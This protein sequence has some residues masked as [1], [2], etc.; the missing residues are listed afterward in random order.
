[1]G[2]GGAAKRQ[3]S[4]AGAHTGQHAPSLPDEIHGL[5]GLQTCLH[6]RDGDEQGG[7][8]QARHTVHG[9]GGFCRR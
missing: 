4:K 8:A 3:L 5:H 2:D 9:D 7:A 6:Q 1:M